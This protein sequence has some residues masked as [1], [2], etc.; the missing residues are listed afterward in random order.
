MAQVE[1]TD[2][3]L[4]IRLERADRLWAFRGQ[5]E[6]PL[7]HVAGVEV[8]PEQARVPWSGLPVRNAGSWAPGVLAAGSVR[9]EGEWAFWDVRDPERAVIIHLADERFARL[10]VEVDDPAAT[11]ATIRQAIDGH[12]GVAAT[13]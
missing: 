9:H 3:R 13:G 10:V 2:N 7:D 11:A 8:D 6:V 4:A 12:S 5:L 1:L